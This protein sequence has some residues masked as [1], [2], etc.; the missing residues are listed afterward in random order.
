MST[1]IDIRRE[2]RQDTAAK[3]VRHFQA[4]Q[5]DGVVNH[6]KSSRGVQQR[7]HRQVAVI[8][9]LEYVRQYFN[10]CCVRGVVRS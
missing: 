4:M 10:N 7:Q 6:I 5:Q 1:T 2:S 3:T 9:H 8:K